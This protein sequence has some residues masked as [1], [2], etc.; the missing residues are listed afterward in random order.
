MPTATYLDDTRIRAVFQRMLD[1][2]PDSR[3]YA[4]GYASDADHIS[5]GGTLARGRAEIADGHEAVLSTWGRDSH[6]AGRIDRLQFLTADVA[7]LT[8]YTDI[9]FGAK[10]SG[11]QTRRTIQSITAQKIDQSWALAT[12]QYTPLGPWPRS[13]DTSTPPLSADD[14]SAPAPAPA[15]TPRDGDGLKIRALYRRML[16]CWLDAPAYAECFTPDADYITG[17]GRLERGWRENVEGH[18]IIFSAWARAS[19]LAGRIEGIRFLTADVAV[20]T[21][22]GHIIFQDHRADPGKRTIYT[23]TAQRI[24]GSW[25]FVGYQNTPLIGD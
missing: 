15:T 19:R 20:V 10:P 4:A 14:P 8:V 23:A 25:I 6:L 11:G 5:T 18:Q 1:G 13:A 22:Y 24:D 7:L 16:D 17:G 9:S 2:W 21:A 12:C 3:S